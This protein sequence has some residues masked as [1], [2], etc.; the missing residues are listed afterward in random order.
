MPFSK[1]NIRLKKMNMKNKILTQG[2]VVAAVLIFLPLQAEDLV[3]SHGG[4]TKVV[5]ATTVTNPRPGTANVALN[6]TPEEQKYPLATSNSEYNSLSIFA[7]KCAI[8]G[9]T[10][11][12]GHGGAFP[13]WGPHKR[14]DLWLKID[15][16]KEVEVEKIVIY[17]RADFTPYTADDHDSYWKTGTIEFSDGTKCAY[18]LSRTA[19]G[20]EISFPSRNVE[21]VKL[22][23]LVPFKDLWCAFTEVQVWGK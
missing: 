16:G 9:N 1:I 21:W 2:S 6:A 19:D 7:A 8:N 13:S 10:S 20:Q 11:N 23:D 12:K 15:F 22:T 17:V 5:V 18:E 14:P 4:S 3:S